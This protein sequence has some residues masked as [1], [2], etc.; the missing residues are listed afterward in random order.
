LPRCAAPND[1]AGALNL[2]PRSE[3]EGVPGP[4][5]SEDDATRKQSYD[6]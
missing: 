3:I 1:D 2:I 4:E 6:A 5:S